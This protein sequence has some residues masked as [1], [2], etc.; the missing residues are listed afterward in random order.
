MQPLRADVRHPARRAAAGPRHDPAP[1][2]LAYR[3]ERLRLT[4][5]FRKALRTGLPLALVALAIGGWLG[6]AGRRADLV[7]RYE[8]VKTQIQNRPEFMVNLMEID[9]ASPAVDRTIRQLLPI[10]FPVSSFRLDLEALR[11]VIERIDAVAGADLHIRSG[12]VMQITVRERVPVL[13]WRRDAGMELLDAT[14]HRVATLLSREARA[15]LPLIAGAGADARVPEALAILTAADPILRRVRGL[16]RMGERRWDI[17][18]DRDQR[19]LLPETDPVA[20]VQRVVALNEAEELL[21]R[22]LVVVDMRHPDRPTLRLSAM[23]ID[24]LRTPQTEETEAPAP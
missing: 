5:L 7:A 10:D 6:D 12:G 14:G 2:R 19:V 22:D 11:Q 3:I 8:A 4:P 13:V 23:A 24:A 18:L 16:V 1:S 9:G 15:D 20:A 17:V 21:D